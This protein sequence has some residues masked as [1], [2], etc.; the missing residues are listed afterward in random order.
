MLPEWEQQLSATNMKKSSLILAIALFLAAPSDQSA[1]AQE[2]TE[3]EVANGG[4]IEGRVM[5]G[6]DAPAP[7]RLLITKDAEI[8]GL[9]YRE[10]TEYDVADD[11]ALRRVVVFIEDISEGKSWDMA[12]P[13]EFVNQ[14]VCAFTPNIQVMRRASE[15]DI[16]N[17]DSTL[18]NI[19]G[20]E[21]IGRARRS[22]FNI[23]QPDLGP[24]P[25]VLHP[26][27][28]H[29]VSLECDS[30]DFMQGWIFASDNPYATVV[31]ETGNFQ[32]SDVP[33]GTYEVSVW[34]PKLGIQTQTVTVT[35]QSSAESNFEFTID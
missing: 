1:F 32:L 11:G 18:H 10:R 27:R 13:R 23:S 15:M 26:A 28:S 14:E 21:L 2:Y 19:H 8:C 34:H 30:H 35:S 3:I 7:L 12:A 33:P 31:D 6:G 22:L 4:S 24:V 25:Q 20:Y 17:S 9:G 16:I 29:L 5:F